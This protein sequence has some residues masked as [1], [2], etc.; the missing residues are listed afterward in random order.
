MTA[1]PRAR[2]FNKQESFKDYI[3]KR[4]TTSEIEI[5]CLLK[6]KT[7]KKSL[8]KGQQDDHTDLY[9]LDKPIS[10]EYKEVFFLF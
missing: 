8:I 9:H 5:N 4:A 1:V 10:T 2:V 3:L 6:G 7:K